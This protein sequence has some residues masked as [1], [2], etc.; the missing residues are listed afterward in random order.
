MNDKDAEAILVI[1][2]C[3]VGIICG[4]AVANKRGIMLG[5]L[6]SVLKQSARK[7]VVRERRRKPFYSYLGVAFVVVTAVALLFTRNLAQLAFFIS[8][9]M[10]SI[11]YLLNYFILLEP[12]DNSE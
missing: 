10:L 6:T 1:I 2:T 11:A 3:L 8:F 9:N 12:K 5:S 4:I 7:Y